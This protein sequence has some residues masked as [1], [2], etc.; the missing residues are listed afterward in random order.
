L[1]VY[2]Y[3]ETFSQFPGDV[4]NKITTDD[5]S[6]CLAYLKIKNDENKRAIDK[7]KRKPRPTRPKAPSP[8]GR[9]R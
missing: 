5:I 4:E 6:E 3:A 7:A 2:L 9:R 1:A 8:K